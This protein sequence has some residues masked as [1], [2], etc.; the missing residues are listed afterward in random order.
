[1]AGP[2]DIIKD[3]S[4]WVNPR[5]YEAVNS[6]D[7]QLRIGL[8]KS[9]Y[10]DEKT[11]DVRYLVEVRDRNDAIELNCRMLRRFGG[12]Y[13]YEDVIFRGYKIE[14][15]PDPTASFEA[16]AGDVVLVAMMN[17]EGRDGIILGGVMHAARTSTINPA[18]GP[19]YKSEFNGLETS[20][21]KDGEYTLTFRGLQTNIG[22]LNDIPSARIAPPTYNTSVGTTYIK[23]DKTGSFEVNDNAT[24]NP[25][26][27]KIDKPGGTITVLSGK[28][29]L[30]MTKASE[31]V[32]LKAKT[33]NV[34]AATSIKLTTKIFHT[35]ADSTATIDSPKLAFGTG[36][37]ELL[38]MV[39]QLCQEV[40]NIA[41]ENS[42]EIHP[43]NVGPSGP[44]NNAPKYVDAATKAGKIKSKVDSIKGT[45]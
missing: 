26:N 19:Q 14:D 27:I 3:S 34:N 41:T 5:N 42:T 36:G 16:K 39:S 28:I 17:G 37:V 12:V 38:E 45:L 23:L 44:P 13:N 4:I 2:H 24:S 21:N 29:S 10:L 32:T 31:D 25:Q 7:T 40:I 6:K 11:S 30:K 43:T 1:M 33:L 15:K 8:V 9:I 22:K 18:E 20:V 35:K